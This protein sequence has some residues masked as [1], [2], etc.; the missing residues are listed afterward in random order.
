MWKQVQWSVAMPG[1]GF[2]DLTARG[3]A[4]VAE[5]GVSIGLCHFFLAHT[6]ASLCITENADPDVRRDLQMI[7]GR[8][9]PDGSPTYRHD[10]EGPDDM[11]AHAR[12]L[13]AGYELTVP[14]AK[15]RL[16]LGTWQGIYLWEHRAG[17]QQ[18]TVVVT[19]NG[20]A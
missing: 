20:S 3:Q 11:S 12:T 16:Q 1:R 10:A 5:S 17:P 18:R 19:L 9:A 2:N 7:A 6:S 8:L 13:L 15:G 4:F 14:V